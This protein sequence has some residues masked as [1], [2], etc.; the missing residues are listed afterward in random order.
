MFA[1]QPENHLVLLL[2]IEHFEMV[3]YLVLV[4]RLQ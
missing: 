3:D 2:E 4:F 1:W